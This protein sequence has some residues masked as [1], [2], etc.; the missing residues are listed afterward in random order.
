LFKLRGPVLAACALIGLAI[1]VTAAQSSASEGLETRLGFSICPNVTTTSYPTTPG[2]SVQGCGSPVMS[3]NDR[4]NECDAPR[5]D[6]DLGVF[7]TAQSPLGVFVASGAPNNCATNP[8]TLGQGAV[9]AA[10]D[11]SVVQRGFCPTSFAVSVREG[12]VGSV[13][14]PIGSPPLGTYDVTVRLPPQTASTPSGPRTWAGIDVHGVLRVGTKF[15]EVDTHALVTRNRFA[16]LLQNSFAGFGAGALSASRSGKTTRL[17][18][19]DYYACGT[20][21]VSATVTYGKRGAIRGSGAFTGGTGNYLNIK[22]DFIVRGSYS[23]KTGRGK[24]IFTGEANF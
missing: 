14:F 24:L 6:P 13:L 18:G 1:S 5:T 23:I 9:G 16:A 19:I 20:I 4:Q 3:K 8:P 21:D 2:M 22:G 7:A 11:V 10:I 17:T 12:P 15:K